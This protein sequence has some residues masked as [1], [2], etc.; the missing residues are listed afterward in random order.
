MEMGH[1]LS[2]QPDSKCYHLHGHSWWVYLTIEGEPDDKGMILD[3]TTVKHKFRE[4]LDE[5]FDHH[6]LLN[7]YD[8]LVQILE[9]VEAIEW[10][11]VTCGGF[12]PTVE[13]V[14]QLIYNWAAHTFGAYYQYHVELYEAATNAAE[15]GDL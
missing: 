3:F 4:Y 7:T 12:D 13:N 14:A 1:R 5:N 6:M 8:P 9:K 11:I 2:L 10:G 15:Y